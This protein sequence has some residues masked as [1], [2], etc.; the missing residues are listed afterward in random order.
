MEK[1]MLGLVVKKLVE[2]S[3]NILGIIYDLLEK[4]TGEAGQE[5][6]AE[7]KKF[8]RKEKCWTDTLLEF[9][10]TVIVPATTEKFIVR[11]HFI[12][13]TS[14]KAKVKISGLGTKFRE[15][16]LGKIEEPIGRTKLHCNKLRRSSDDELILAELT[17]LGKNIEPVYL[18]KK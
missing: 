1:D 14:E 18:K 5:W 7:L 16:F 15:N 13:D 12:V 6:L 4:L 8:L 3:L 17:E 11:D 2:L 9:I 10:G